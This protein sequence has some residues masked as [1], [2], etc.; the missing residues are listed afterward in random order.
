MKWLEGKK[1]NIAAGGAIVLG[2]AGAFFGVLDFA[3][4]T[5]LI[6]FGLGFYGLRDAIGRA[7]AE[8]IAQRA[9]DEG[10]KRRGSK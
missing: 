2:I 1:T 10:Q 6:V 3:E 8:K 7:I 9:I 4:A 5:T